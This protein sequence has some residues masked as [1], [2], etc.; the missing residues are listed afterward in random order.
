MK[1]DKVESIQLNLGDPAQSYQI[2]NFLNAVDELCCTM[3]ATR[4][5]TDVEMADALDLY[6]KRL[7]Y[8]NP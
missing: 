7:R 4:D 3:H 1:D 2:G 6:I 8:D 5:I